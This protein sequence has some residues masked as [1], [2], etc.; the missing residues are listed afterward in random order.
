MNFSNV[1]K[2]ISGGLAGGG[3]SML[4]DFLGGTGL[5]PAVTMG[6]GNQISLNTLLIVAAVG[7]AVYFTKNK[8]AK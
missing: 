2:M 4:L 8:A 3:A 6:D 1:S 7:I 5:K